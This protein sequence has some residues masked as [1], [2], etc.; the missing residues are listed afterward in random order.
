MRVRVGP[1][2]PREEGRGQKGGLRGPARPPPEWGPAPLSARGPWAPR[3]QDKRSREGPQ[4]HCAWTR[5]AGAR[6]PSRVPPPA[7]HQPPH[8]HPAARRSP[9][10][11][12]HAEQVAA[13]GRAGD[14]HR[15]VVLAVAARP[16]APA[17]AP[18]VAG[19]PARPHPAAGPCRAPLARPLPRRPPLP[20]AADARP[21][22]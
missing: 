11:G 20:P 7:P 3:G 10:L 8:P 14:P 9:G 12:P 1:W 19:V 13:A 5:E 21:Y 17:R 2:A 22:L 18:A 4:G 16:G 6:V 15:P